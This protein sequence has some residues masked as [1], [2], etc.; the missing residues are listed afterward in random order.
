MYEYNNMYLPIPKHTYY[1]RARR[2]PTGYVKVNTNSSGKKKQKAHSLNNSEKI[3][4]VYDGYLT[5]II[6]YI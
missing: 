1:D 5:I 4:L 3:K 2:V 6:Y